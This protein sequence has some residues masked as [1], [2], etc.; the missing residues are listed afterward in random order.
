MTKDTYQ[1]HAALT[2]EFH[3]KTKLPLFTSNQ[4]KSWGKS[5]VFYHLQHQHDNNF[6]NHSSNTEYCL[7]KIDL[8]QDKEANIG[9]NNCD[10]LRLA[11]LMHIFK[12]I[13]AEIFIIRYRALQMVHESR[14]LF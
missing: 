5:F 8:V 2:S 10:F 3:V 9:I 4:P 14:S 1:G 13:T 7:C 6:T 12:R 11:S